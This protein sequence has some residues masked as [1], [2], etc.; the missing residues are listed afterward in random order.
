MQCSE[1]RFRKIHVSTVINAQWLNRNRGIALC[2]PLLG[3]GLC[4]MQKEAGGKTSVKGG[5]WKRSISSNRE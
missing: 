5:Y 2:G 1:K 3:K 4:W